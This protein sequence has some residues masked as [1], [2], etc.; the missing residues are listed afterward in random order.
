MF[1]SRVEV[2][3]LV[4]SQ[5][6]LTQFGEVVITT[7]VGS[8]GDFTSLKLKYSYFDDQ[9]ENLITS[10]MQLQDLEGGMEEGDSSGFGDGP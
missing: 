2:A 5:T 3:K 6:R 10:D 9:F 1:A 7:Q 8:A 4:N